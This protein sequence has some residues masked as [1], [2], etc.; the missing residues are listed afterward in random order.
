[1]QLCVLCAFVFIKF[2]CFDMGGNMADKRFK[3]Y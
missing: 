1:M 3:K 2:H